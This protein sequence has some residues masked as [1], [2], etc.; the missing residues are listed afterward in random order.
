MDL[1]AIIVAGGRGER[2]GDGLPKQYRP[3]GGRS[4]LRWSLDALSSMRCV[5]VIE[6]THAALF[7]EA[8]GGLEVEWVAGGATRTESVRAGLAALAARP[9]EIVLIHDAARPGLRPAMIEAL[10]GPLKRGEA[11][12]TAPAL[13]IADALKQANADGAVMGEAPRE[14]LW[15]VQTPQA[16]RYGAIKA[17]YDALPAGAVHDDDLA[18]ACAAGHKALLTPGDIALSKITHPEDFAIME[19]L[20]APQP[21][22]CVGT[23][24]DAHRFGPG[25]H[26]TL[27]GVKIAHTKGIVGHSD[28]DVGWHALTDAL[29]GAIGNGDI[30]AHFP[31]SDPQW[32]GASSEIFL[33]RA[34]QLVG[35]GGGRIAHVDVT[36]ICE[37]P[38]IGPH[39]DAMR[40]RTAE[41]LGLPLA[42]VSVKATTT[43]AM[44][45][46]GREEGMAAQASASVEMP[47]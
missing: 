38:K 7:K 28:A 25:D 45:F 9:P 43:E 23:G 26:V 47:R 19:R 41:V 5:A 22:V 1:A 31:P 6:P 17:A 42:R 21:L 32:K 4:V 37:R 18:V 35:E 11:A 34:A 12:A 15:R 27:C 10:I 8:A 20:L 40:A 33:R 39:R 44:G 36:L 14:A 30:G 3:L 29:L 16:F 2:A 46:T 13:P 24:F